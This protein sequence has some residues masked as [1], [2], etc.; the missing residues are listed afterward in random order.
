MGGILENAMHE[1]GKDPVY[2]M[3][4]WTSELLWLMC[5]KLIERK[6]READAKAPKRKTLNFSEF[7]ST[8]G[9]E[10]TKI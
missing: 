8:M 9:G 4:N 6:Y 3:N 10:V 7:M 1:W 5:N 2:I